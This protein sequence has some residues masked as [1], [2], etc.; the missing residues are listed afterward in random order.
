MCF[1]VFWEKIKRFQGSRF[2]FCSCCSSPSSYIA[3]KSVKIY[4]YEISDKMSNKNRYKGNCKV[5][6]D[7][8]KRFGFLSCGDK[9]THKR[10]SQHPPNNA[11]KNCL[12]QGKY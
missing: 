6:P 9:A 5:F 10:K 12:G 7:N 4:P 8:D 3:T 2:Y 11:Y 1:S